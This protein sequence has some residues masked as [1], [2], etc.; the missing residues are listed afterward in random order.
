MKVGRWAARLTAAFAVLWLAIGILLACG[1]PIAAW[2][3]EGR[4]DGVG[5]L[6]ALAVLPLLGATLILL[7]RGKPIRAV[8]C[9]GTAALALYVSAFAY[10]LPRLQTVWMSPRIAEAVARVR[11]CAET[12]VA[13]VS[14]KEPSLV[15]LLGT[16]TK[17][18]DVEGAAD[19]LR[20]DPACALALIGARERS[21][22]LALME[23][24]GMEPR[25]LDRIRGL[26]YSNGRWLDLTLFTVSPAG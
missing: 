9:A 24:A 22:F 15:F 6:V 1:L 18:T 14:Y 26:D 17:L 23:T 25:E 8:A 2:K 3:L 11:P 21:Q 4:I 5:M 7:H 16:R 12:T 13:S 19:H 10:Q 20:G